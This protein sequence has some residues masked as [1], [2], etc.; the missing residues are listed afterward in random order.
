MYK[1]KFHSETLKNGSINTA[2]SGWV[3]YRNEDE[4]EYVNDILFESRK[5]AD[6][7]LDRLKLMG[8]AE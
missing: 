2:K 4:T 8:F 1:V 3:I 6:T 7:Y 5:E